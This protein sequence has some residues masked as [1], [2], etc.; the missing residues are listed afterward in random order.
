M[1][2]ITPEV[3]MICNLQNIKYGLLADYSDEEIFKT[4]LQNVSFTD[5]LIAEHLNKQQNSS[6]EAKYLP[7]NASSFRKY[8]ESQVNVQS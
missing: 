3:S 2:E 8:Q 4:I 7:R 5:S 6:N 1:K